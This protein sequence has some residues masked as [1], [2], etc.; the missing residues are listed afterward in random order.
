MN[1]VYCITI[2]IYRAMLKKECLLQIMM[3]KFSSQKSEWHQPQIVLIKT[4]VL[5]GGA[6]QFLGEGV[7]STN[8]R[9][10]RTRREGAGRAR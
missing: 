6:D 7:S 5:Q 4:K 9:P 2:H 10:D 3:E 8:S 1:T